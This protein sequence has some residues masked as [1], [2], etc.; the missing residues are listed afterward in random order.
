M[1]ACS[2]PF[3]SGRTHSGGD[4][5]FHVIIGLLL[6][7]YSC[8]HPDGQLEFAQALLTS[9]TVMGKAPPVHRRPDVSMQRQQHATRGLLM[10]DP[11]QQHHAVVTTRPGAMLQIAENIPT[12]RKLDVLLRYC[13]KE[14]GCF[15]PT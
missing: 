10:F 12:W 3:R 11:A 2:A 7:P 6:I 13:A 4:A 14:G 15:R 9:L 1:S 5:P 8:Q